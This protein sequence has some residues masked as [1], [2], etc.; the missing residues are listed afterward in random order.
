MHHQSLRIMLHGCSD[1]YQWQSVADDLQHMI[2]GAHGELRGAHRDLLISADIR[3]AGRN[4]YVQAFL[5]VVA[6]NL[7]VVEATVLRLRIP[8]RL[9]HDR[10]KAAGGLLLSA[11]RQHKADAQR[12]DSQK[13]EPH[14]FEPSMAAKASSLASEP[15]AATN[16]TPPPLAASVTTG[17]PARLAGVVYRKIFW[18]VAEGSAPT[19]RALMGA[20]GRM[21][22][23]YC[24]SKRSI[25]R[26]KAT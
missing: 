15:R 8:I 7:R 2:R 9:Q 18:R 25:F 24:S 4:G 5:F 6:A 1:S 20:Q 10:R 13:R 12:A 23:S 14:A 3:S 11:A 19:C 16:C 21:R 17:V 26:R 22:K